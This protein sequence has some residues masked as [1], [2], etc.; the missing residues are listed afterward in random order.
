MS[1][2][3]LHLAAGSL[4]FYL[5]S[6]ATIFSAF[7]LPIVGAMV[8]RSPRKKCAHGRLRVGRRLLLRR[9]CSS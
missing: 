3:G 7:I 1:L 8:D 4:P 6:F 2:L 9:C 5:T